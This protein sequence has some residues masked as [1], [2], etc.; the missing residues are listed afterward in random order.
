MPVGADGLLRLT[1]SMTYK[2]QT[3]NNLFWARPKPDDPSPTWQALCDHMS[4]DFIIGVWPRMANLMCSG[5]KLDGTITRVLTGG[6]AQTIA[7]Y[8]TEFGNV[9]GDGLPPHDAAVLS[10]YTMYPGR[11]VH[12]RLYIGG[13][14]ESRQEQ[15][16]LNTDGLFYL[17]QLGAWLI[18]NFGEDGYSP[19]YWWGVYSR[20]NGVVRQPGPPP[21]LSYSPLAH[22]PWY[23]WSPSKVLGTQR[24]RRIGRGQ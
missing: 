3:M 16:E 22:V 20:S 15:G 5:V 6:Q 18:Q 21:F 14:P 17:N 4:N 23:R 19:Y 24:H 8:T 11:R 10:L 2:N 13:I 12:G 1:V 9:A 7:P